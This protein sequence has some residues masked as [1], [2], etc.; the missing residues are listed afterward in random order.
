MQIFCVTSFL[1]L[2]GLIIYTV[3]LYPLLLVWLAAR[4]ARPV[5]K[6]EGRRTVSIIVA[7]Y[8]GG[9]FIA[10]K[11]NS[12]IELDYPSELIQILVVSDGSTDETE[13][14][15]ARFAERGVQLIR[16]AK[17]GKPAAINAGIAASTG[18]I[19]VLTDVRQTLERPSVSHLVACFAD[20]TVGVVSGNLII[21]QGDLEESNVGAY[22][23]YESWIRKQL[24]RIDSTLGAT[25][26]FYAIRRE[27]AVPI[28]VDTLL[29]DVYLPLSA[30]FRGYRLVVAEEARAFD[31][32]TNVNIEF[33]RKVRTLAGNYQLLWHYPALLTTANRMLFHYVSYKLMRL[34]LPWMFLLLLFTSFWLPWPWSIAALSAQGLFY[35]MAALDLAA[36]GVLK[37]LTSPARTVVSML[38]ASACAVKIFYVSPLEIWKP[39]EVRVEGKH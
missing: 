27:L 1:L 18:E 8:N 12:I 34:M 25:G 35:G 24:G 2:C 17:G 3:A 31:Y 10:D 19:L 15:A 39:T 32:P 30:F 23:R 36:S 9:P 29:D 33:G 22:W 14:I 4:F 37:R 6:R 20:S 11:L 7:V 21:R 26:P 16:T 5:F 13:S 38:L 28:P